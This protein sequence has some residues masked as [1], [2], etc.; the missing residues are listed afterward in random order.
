MERHWGCHLP[1]IL[2]THKNVD[3]KNPKIEVYMF[4][5]V[6]LPVAKVS[7]FYYIFACYLS[8]DSI[9]IFNCQYLCSNNK[10]S[11][12]MVLMSLS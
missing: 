11:I 12:N 5:S 6:Y 7:S 8:G 1:G 4:P 9:F 10:T 3:T 2:W